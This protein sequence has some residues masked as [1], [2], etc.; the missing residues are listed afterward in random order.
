MQQLGSLLLS[1]FLSVSQVNMFLRTMSALNRRMGCLWRRKY[2]SD[3]VARDQRDKLLHSSSATSWLLAGIM[4]AFFLSGLVLMKMNLPRNLRGEFSSALKGSGDFFFDTRIT[5]AV[6]ALSS[7]LT[8][9]I[10]S[11]LFGIRRQSSNLHLAASIS[12]IHGAN[13]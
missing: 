9:A 2:Q 6:F 13:V 11:I 3:F 12:Q 10:L 5:N 4:G 1:A 8:A 7:I